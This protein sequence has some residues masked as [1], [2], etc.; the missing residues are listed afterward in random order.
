LGLRPLSRRG[1][2]RQQA[3]GN[4]QHPCHGLSS[5]GFGPLPAGHFFAGV[6]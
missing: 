1:N 6:R 4:Q 5:R 3:S 2:K